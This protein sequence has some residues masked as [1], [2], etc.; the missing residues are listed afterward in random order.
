M[1]IEIAPDTFA[2]VE[3]VVATGQYPTA[4]EAVAEGVRL[5]IARNK[6]RE[7]IQIGID[8][9]ENGRVHSHEEVFAELRATASRLA[10]PSR[11][12]S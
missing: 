8:D 3:S 4:N 2:L 6:L 11:E 10:N 9:I 1:N 5:L 12:P 7:E